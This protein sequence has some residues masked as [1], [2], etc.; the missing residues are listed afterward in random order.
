MGHPDRPDSAVKAPWSETEA[1][2]NILQ[3]EITL[4]LP[5]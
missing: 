2:A 4:Y 1:L 3:E 5:L